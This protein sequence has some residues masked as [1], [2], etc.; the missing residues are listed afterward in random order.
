MA[1]RPARLHARVLGAPAPRGP[2]LSPFQIVL[3][4]FV[5]LIAAGTALLSLPGLHAGPQTWVDNLFMATSA[6]CVTGLAT[7]D[8]ATAYTLPG[9]V[10]LLALVQVGGLGYMTLLSISLVLVGRRLSMRDR[11]NL[12]HATDQ[13]GL[14]G[15]LPLLVSIAAFTAAIEALGTAALAIAFVP[16][17]GFG[18]GLWLA[19]FH[20]VSAF[21]N[22]GFTL[23]TEGAVRFQHALPVLGVLGALVAIGSLGYNV[24]KE[25][26]DRF[27]LRRGARAR[28]SPLAIVVLAMTAALTAGGMLVFWALEHGNPATLGPMSVL[29]QGVH[30]W[31]L[32]VQPRSGGFNGV[33]TAALGRP[34]QLFT[35]VLMFV[36]G[37]PGGTAG[38]IKVTTLA[39]L[40]A[41][42]V[43]TVRGTRDV[44]LPG[45]RRRL[46]VNVIR[47]AVSV[48]SLTLF[49]TMGMTIVIASIEPFDL[50][51]I[52]F[53]VVS[54]SA[55]V[56]LSLGITAKLSATS[57][58]LLVASMLIGRIGILTLLLA[59]HTSRRRSAVRYAEEPLMIG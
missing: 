27:V 5:A 12:S 33:D 59:L 45:M 46:E 21:N 3:L 51:P 55:T 35:I 26:V 17:F 25:L 24:N 9:Q 31:F 57:K 54:A 50:L 41:V 29:E 30:A 1:F 11:V 19:I 34:T 42:A 6:V 49:A 58:V 43:A 32:A 4:S 2:R 7:V 52:L 14:G 16:E 22:A 23:F 48:A 18:R 36:G 15:L 38:G 8:V 44:N 20:S 40:I 56:G 10:V 13:A 53:E 37:G 47:R 39:V 28:L